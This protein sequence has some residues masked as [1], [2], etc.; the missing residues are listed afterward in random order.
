M[1][2]SPERWLTKR[3]HRPWSSRGVVVIIIQ[4]IYPFDHVSTSNRTNLF[5]LLGLF[6]ASGAGSLLAL[7]LLE[8]GLRHKDLVL[9]RNTVH[10]QGQYSLSGGRNS[11]S[12]SRKNCSIVPHSQTG[13]RKELDEIHL[14]GEK[15]DPILPCYYSSPFYRQT[16][17]AGTE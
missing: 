15:G 14:V 16:R 13:A 1:V 12:P 11:K 5:S 6:A 17:F 3:Q 7:T 9:G 8:E 4:P 2:V 10:M